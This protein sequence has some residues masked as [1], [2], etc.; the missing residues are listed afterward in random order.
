M[1]FKMPANGA[2]AADPFGMGAGRDLLAQ[3]EA[4]RRSQ[5]THLIRRQKAARCGSEQAQAVSGW[6]ILDDG[7]EQ[8][9]S[10]EIS[11]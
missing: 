11:I 8:A 9:V 5:G 2:D 7:L 10:D 6:F 3:V 1:S 4:G